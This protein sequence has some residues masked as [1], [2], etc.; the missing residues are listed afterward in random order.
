MFEVKH[1]GRDLRA[2]F[3]VHYCNSGLFH[4]KTHVPRGVFITRSPPFFL[5]TRA[6][7]PQSDHCSLFQSGLWGISFSTSSSDELY[8]V[9]L[10]AD[11]GCWWQC[12]RLVWIYQVRIG[13]LPLVFFYA[14]RGLVD[15]Q[16][17]YFHF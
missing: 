2:V 16:G 10:E 11:R 13:A 6:A 8:E 17:R 15:V 12:G 3:D 7:Q 5:P 9:G 4:T 1:M 14:A